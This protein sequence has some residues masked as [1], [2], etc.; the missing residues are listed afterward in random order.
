[1]GTHKLTSTTLLKIKKRG[2]PLVECVLSVKPHATAQKD[3]NG[4]KCLKKNEQDSGCK[5]SGKKPIKQ[6]IDG[7]DVGNVL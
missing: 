5:K 3:M 7:H 4:K 6:K 1:M 2:P